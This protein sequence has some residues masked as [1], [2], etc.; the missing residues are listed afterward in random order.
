MSPDVIAHV[1]PWLR[2]KT[3]T[4]AAPARLTSQKPALGRSDA[5][6]HAAAVVASG[7]MPSTTP[8]CA[9]GT[10]VIA[11]A[12]STGKA[13]VEHSAAAIRRP[14]SARGGS[15]RRNSSSSSRPAQPA[16]VVRAAV[17]NSGSIE[18]T[19]SRV[20]GS[21]PAN[22]RTPAQPSAIPS[23]SPDIAMPGSARRQ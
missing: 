7:M 16:M 4:I 23:L 11:S 1:S 9:A 5:T 19:A 6:T 14:H 20:A 22:S 12:I 8:P 10:V 13:T 15:G 3:V 2:T 18:P 21:V 17:K